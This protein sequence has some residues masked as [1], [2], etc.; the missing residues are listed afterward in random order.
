[1]FFYLHLWYSREK[2]QL[3]QIGTQLGTEAVNTHRV[4]DRLTPRE[5]DGF[6]D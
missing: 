3:G 6:G 2:F 1:M 5:L 4:W